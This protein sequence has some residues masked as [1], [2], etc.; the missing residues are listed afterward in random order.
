MWL[1]NCGIDSDFTISKDEF[2]HL[3]TEISDTKNHRVL[4]LHDIFFII[5]S[6]QNRLIE[7]KE[8]FV[9][10]YKE[11]C[12]INQDH[13]IDDEGE[14]VIYWMSGRKTI[15]I[16][17]MF[18][19]MIV[20]LYSIFDLMTKLVIESNHEYTDYS[21]WPK[22]ASKEILY[23]DKNKF[24]DLSWNGT[25]YEKTE[26]INMIINYRHE[27]I[28]NGSFEYQNKIYFNYR[29]KELHEKYVYLIDYTDGN[30]DTVKNRKRFYSKGLKINY[31]LPVIYFDVLNK[32]ENTIQ[33]LQ[34]NFI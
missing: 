11:L 12:N 32:I 29:N 3:V 2:A 14:N 24:F 4:L 6:I 25:I 33:R 9:T 15:V 16:Y 21:K 1:S 8:L 7:T 23:G 20:K 18:E 19:N 5:A 30:I 22:L 28:H 31:E 10:F 13:V 34:R 17:S 27:I 26:S